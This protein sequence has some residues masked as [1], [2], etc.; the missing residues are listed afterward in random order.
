MINCSHCYN[1]KSVIV[2]SGAI[3][4]FEFEKRCLI[5][6]KVN[7]WN[8]SVLARSWKDWWKGTL[9]NASWSDETILYYLEPGKMDE[10]NASDMEA[11]LMK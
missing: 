6:Y 8:N 7:W 1:C 2:L 3:N 11:G 9:L 10:K 4:E 5:N